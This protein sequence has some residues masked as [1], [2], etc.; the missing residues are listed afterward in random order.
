ME[1]GV[2]IVNVKDIKTEPVQWEGIKIE[3]M[4]TGYECE[5][6]SEFVIKREK[7]DL[8]NNPLDSEP[9]CEFES[10]TESESSEVKKR[11]SEYDPDIT[12]DDFST[13]DDDSISSADLTKESSEENDE[14]N[15][16]DSYI[17]SAERFECIHCK[18]LVKNLENHVERNHL[19]FTK[20]VNRTICGLCLK[21][22]PRRI[23]LKNHQITVHNGNAFACDICDRM[24]PK[25]AEIQRHII[26]AHSHERTFLCQHCGIGYKFIRD[27]Q[28]HIQKLHMGV[29]RERNAACDLCEKKF[30]T[31]KSL[32]RHIDSVHLNLRPY[33]CRVDGCSKAFKQKNYLVT[34]ERQVHTKE[35]VYSCIVCEKQFSFKQNLATH[36]KNIHKT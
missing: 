5:A 27:L 28:R 2:A 24:T 32:K 9:E 17:E 23:N 10:E 30:F 20:N 33:H 16:E 35:R 22:F 7:L 15:D 25:Y 6:N 14:E 4:D 1:D 11:K 31:T 12:S 3:P 19:N 34:H 18:Q 36:I 8:H 13:T 29:I 26:R 21:T